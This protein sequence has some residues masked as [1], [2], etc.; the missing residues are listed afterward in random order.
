MIRGAVLALTLG[1]VGLAVAL[2]LHGGAGNA[3][4]RVLGRFHV[5]VLHVPIGALVVALVAEATT[6]AR[7]I[8]RRADVVVFSALL[9]FVPTAFVAIVLGLLLA[10]GGHQ[11]RALVVPH[12]NLEVVCL[13]LAGACLVAWPHR[14]RNGRLGHRVVLA[15]SAVAM[16]AGAHFGGSMT[17]GEGFL[18][19]SPSDVPP[20]PAAPGTATAEAAAGTAPMPGAGTAPP[21]AVVPVPTTDAGA[22]DASPPV[23]SAPGSASSVAPTSPTGPAT[24]S[25]KPVAVSSPNRAAA[26]AIVNRRC[27]PCHTTGKKGGLRL[28]DLA[29]PL[30]KGVLVPGNPGAS[31]LYT[32]VVTPLDDD[33]HMPPSESPQPTAGEIATLRAFVAEPKR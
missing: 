20:D 16:I 26:Q 29:A 25:A 19:A 7:R 5:V 1:A 30:P 27:G 8:R 28:T 6:F 31:A 15:L 18:T 32:R 33:E 22:T 4:V 14:W 23:G 3:V 10:Y 17:H 2:P 9:V 13:V 24:A 12:R 21:P 11:A